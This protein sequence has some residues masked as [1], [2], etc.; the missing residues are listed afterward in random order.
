MNMFFFLTH[1]EKCMQSV[2]SAS[3]QS[4]FVEADKLDFLHWLPGI[5]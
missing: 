1:A 3:L 5:T 4:E 2:R